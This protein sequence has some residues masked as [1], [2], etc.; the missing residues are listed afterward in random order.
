MMQS[1]IIIMKFIKN[2]IF[3]NPLFFNIK[4]DDCSIKSKS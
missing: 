4:F 3:Y 2:R 1:K